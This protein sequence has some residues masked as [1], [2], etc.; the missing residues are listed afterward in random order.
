MLDVFYYFLD[1]NEMIRL[2]KLGIIAT[3]NSGVNSLKI[4]KLTMENFSS[5]NN[6][7]N[8]DSFKLVVNYVTILRKYFKHIFN[9]LVNT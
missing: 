3:K 4:A 7:Q 2:S 5:K 1:E 8:P 9:F 6:T